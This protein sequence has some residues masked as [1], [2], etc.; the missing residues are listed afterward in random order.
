MSQ[1]SMAHR[2][3]GP[4]VKPD[5]RVDR[6]GH[7]YGWSDD[8]EVCGTEG[9]LHTGGGGSRGLDRVAVSPG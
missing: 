5:A 9:C 1:E 7:R 6:P 3:R 4:R 2:T 8:S